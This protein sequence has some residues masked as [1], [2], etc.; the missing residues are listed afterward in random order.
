MTVYQIIKQLESVSGRNDKIKILEQ[1]K[2]N[3]TLKTFFYLALDP[4]VTFGIKKIPAYKTQEHPYY[5]LDRAMS[6]L[7]ALIKREAT[8]NAGIE[9]LTKILTQ[10]TPESAELICRIIDKDAGCGVAESTVNKI[11]KGL[12]FD[13]PVMKASPHDERSFEN[14]Q[15]PCYS[16]A[17]LDGARCAIII[18]NGT[19]T[20]LSSSGRE[21]TTHGNFDWLSSQF[22]GFVLDGELLMKNQDGSFMDRKTGNGIVNRAV[23]GTIPVDQA[24]GLHFVAFDL[25][26][27]DDWK[28]GVSKWDYVNRFTRLCLADTHGTNVSIVENRTVENEKEVMAHFKEMLAA[29]QEGTIVKDW[30]SIWEGKRRKDHIKFKGLID[31]DLKV[32]GVEPGTGK[33]TGMVGALVCESADGLVRV[34]VGTGLTDDDRRRTDYVG[35]IVR[36]TYN[37]RIKNKTEGSTWSLFLPRFAPEFVRV[38]K[39]VADTIDNIPLKA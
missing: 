3:E 39:D 7:D 2:D 15:F 35:K 5:G 19:V 30:S 18:E 21:I 32:I 1:N 8:G 12:I 29:G 25:I 6:M 26:H 16:Q 9:L 31:C 27:L 37:E 17:K 10:S 24:K 13:F 4:M 23:K 22:E 28:K 34:N 38:D 14:I 11:W 20:C 36:V 33:F